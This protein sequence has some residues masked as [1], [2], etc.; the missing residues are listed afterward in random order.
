MYQ[1][2][3]LKVTCLLCYCSEGDNI[4]DA[5]QLGDAVCKLLQLNHPITGELS[6]SLL[7][8][9]F[10]FCND[11]Y[12]LFIFVVFYN[13]SLFFLSIVCYLAK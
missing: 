7:S 3:G 1:A 11:L 10:F 13:V 2:K 9:L 6:L 8:F 4:S 5:F 12:D